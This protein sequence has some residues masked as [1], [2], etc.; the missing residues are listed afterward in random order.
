[1]ALDA[2]YPRIEPV[3]EGTPRPFWSV[4]IPTYHCAG[5]LAQTLRSV[6]EQDPGADRMQIEV[7]DD[8]STK[9]DPE[10]VVRAVGRGRVGFYRQPAN[11][12]LTHNFNTCL[13][14]ATGEWVHVLHGDDYVLPGFYAALEEGVARE[15][16]IGAAYCRV[17][18]VDEK[19]LW[20]ALW[21]QERKTAGVLEEFAARIAVGQ[22]IQAPSIVVRRSVYERIGGF[23]TA[24]SHTADWDMWKRVAADFKVWY[25][26]RCLACYRSHSG[27]DTS[28]LFRSGENIAQTRRSI[29]LSQTHRP[30]V[31]TP[32][33]S[34][35]ARRNSALYALQIARGYLIKRDLAAVRAQLGEALRC[36][37]EPAVLWELVNLTCWAG[38]R[39]AYQPIKYLR[40]K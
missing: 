32:R 11:G 33:L 24:V 20:Q 19:E 1:M 30:D 4:M 7:V 35:I 22:A 3:P 27:S 31:F 40:R 21:H 2:L 12:G 8:C 6:L 34:R 23:C 26:P 25:E 5:Y 39:T 15:P 14:R 13:R 36:S 17:I 29:E 10:V 18:L 38:V 9:D 28:R 37:Q 16:S